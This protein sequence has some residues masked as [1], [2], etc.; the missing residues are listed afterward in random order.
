M[1][2]YAINLERC[3]EAV[4]RLVIKEI[5]SQWREDFEQREIRNESECLAYFLKPEKGEVKS[6]YVAVLTQA[7]PLSRSDVIGTVGIS[8]KDFNLHISNLL[9]FEQWRLIGLGSKLL[10]FAEDRCRSLGFSTAQLWCSEDLADF[11]EKA[12]WLKQDRIEIDKDKWVRIFMKLID[13]N[14]CIN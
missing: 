1:P 12:G 11:Y 5:F 4:Q 3:S 10:N 8:S 2:L 13:K 9:V 6:L 7:Y 14:V